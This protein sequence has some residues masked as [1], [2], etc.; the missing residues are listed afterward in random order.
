MIVICHPIEL[1]AG[2][3]LFC[4]PSN[5]RIGSLVY[6]QF[7]ER[8]GGRRWRYDCDWPQNATAAVLHSNTASSAG[9]STAAVRTATKKSC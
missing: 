6:E 4:T 7:L 9:G 2:H 5:S 1:V 8:H 3:L